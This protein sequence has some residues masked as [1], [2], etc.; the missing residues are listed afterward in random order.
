MR[1]GNELRAADDA[2]REALLGGEQLVRPARARDRPQPLQQ[3]ERV[4]RLGEEAV[5]EVR[6]EVLPRDLVADL[7]SEPLVERDRVE[8]AGARVLPRL[9]R[10]ELLRQRVELRVALHE[11]ALLGRAES[12]LVTRMATRLAGFVD[13]DVVA[14]AVRRE[15]LDPELVEERVHPRL[16]RGDPLAP[17]LV[18]LASELGV[19][20]TPADTVSRL[21]DDDV[22][23]LG[24]ELA[25]GSEAGDARAHDGDVGLDHAGARASLRRAAAAAA[26]PVRTA[27]SMYPATHWSEPQT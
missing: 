15:E 11:R 3:R 14:L 21:E 8:L 17:E 13:V 2:K 12:V 27:P 9:L 23:A 20:E 25:G 1:S 24:H 10:V 22:A 6:A 19:P 16:V 26:R 18:R 7:A 5:R 4:G